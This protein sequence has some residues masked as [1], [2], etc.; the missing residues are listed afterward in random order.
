[1]GLLRAR[2][3]R[4]TH[5]QINI[6]CREREA[7]ADSIAREIQGN[8]A[9]HRQVELENGDE[10]AMFSAVDRS[11]SKD[12]T[13]KDH[14]PQSARDQSG[15]QSKYVPP[16]RRQNSLNKGSHSSGPM[17]GGGGTCLLNSPLFRSD[18]HPLF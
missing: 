14:S 12:R 16:A 2:D 3:K 10:E 8:M 13:K 17:S 1:M 7:R 4:R 15:G 11:Q 18:I 6:D 9:S 5:E